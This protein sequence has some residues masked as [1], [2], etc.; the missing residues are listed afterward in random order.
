MPLVWDCH[1]HVIG[2]ADK[3]PLS[4]QR[5]YDPSEA[6]FE[7]LLAHMDRVGIDHAVVVQPS[8]YGFDNG[9]LVDALQ[10]SKG[11]LRG[12]AVPPPTATIDDLDMLNR[13]GVKGVRCN[14][15]N[16][17]GLDIGQTRAWWPWMAASGW[18]LQLQI[19]ATGP[20]L[21][22]VLAMEDRPPVVIDHMGYP[23]RGTPPDRL[24]DLIDAVRRSEVFAKISAPYRIS[25]GDAPYDDALTLA[26]ALIE[27]NPDRCLWASDWP[28]TEMTAPVMDDAEWLGRIAA[29]SGPGFARMQDAAQRLYG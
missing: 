6:P 24:R 20:R 29:M 15:V 8:I 26:Q 18:H 10:R 28:H 23:P 21:A 19:D 13:S 11:R 14:L 27:A 1:V 7:S 5:S 3:W 25:A 17:A 9:C 16:P 2:A 4:P 12:I 22:E